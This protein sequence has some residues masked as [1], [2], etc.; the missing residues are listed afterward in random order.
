M[1]KSQNLELNDELKSKIRKQTFL[2]QKQKGIAT[3]VY[4]AWLCTTRHSGSFSASS[5][6][7]IQCNTYCWFEVW[8]QDIGHSLVHHFSPLLII[9]LLPTSSLSL[10]SPLSHLLSPL[11]PSSLP[12]FPSP[13]PRFSFP[14]SP[15][16]SFPPLLPPFCLYMSQTHRQDFMHGTMFRCWICHSM[17]GKP[18]KVCGRDTWLPYRQ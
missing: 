18:T 2:L 10:D 7:L 1:R 8:D 14:F 12:F 15:S 17:T 5:P 9:I 11:S 6:D 16:S 3:C 4:F 13:L